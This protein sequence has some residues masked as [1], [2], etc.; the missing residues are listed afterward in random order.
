MHPCMYERV[1]SV[2]ST[3]YATFLCTGALELFAYALNQIV[4]LIIEM[5]YIWGRIISGTSAQQS[6]SLDM[7]AEGMIL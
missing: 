5:I 2:F 3:I 4:L 1:S 6:I 7:C